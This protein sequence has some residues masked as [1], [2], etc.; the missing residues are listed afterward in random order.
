MKKR[1]QKPNVQTFTTIFSGLANCSNKKVAVAEAVKHY[2]ML[3]QDT[4]LDANIIHTN[5][6]L[7]L[8]SQAHDLDQMLL[9]ANTL[10]NKLRTPDATTYTI[11]FEGIRHKVLAEVKDMEPKESERYRTEM[12]E[13][14]MV[15]WSEVTRKWKAGTLAVDERLIVAMARTYPFQQERNA[16]P[17]DS[18]IL[19]LLQE[20]MGVPNYAKFPDWNKQEAKRREAEPF[21]EEVGRKKTSKAVATSRNRS[22][23]A[24]PG[25]RTLGLILEVLGASRRSSLAIKYWNK[26][27]D[28]FGVQ[29]D[30]DNYFRML[31][32]LKFSKSSSHIAWL[33][34]NSDRNVLNAGHFNVALEAC[35]NDNINT[36]AVNNAQQVLERAK[37]VLPRGNE[38]L[39]KFHR[40]YLRVALVSHHGFRQQSMRGQQRP[41][42]QA[43]G[44][45]ILSALEYLWKPYQDLHRHWFEIAPGSVITDKAAANLSNATSNTQLAAK[46]QNKVF[47][48]APLSQGQVRNSQ[49]E[50]IA[51]ARNIYAAYNKLM[52][53]RMLPEKELA[54]VRAR[55]AS[56]NREIQRF[57]E[58]RGEQEPNLPQRDPSKQDVRRR[59]RLPG[60]ASA[61]DLSAFTDDVFDA[62]EP[63]LVGRG[64][65]EESEDRRLAALAD[66]LAEETAL[67][68]QDLAGLPRVGAEF[69]WASRS[70][71]GAK[72]GTRSAR[73][74]ENQRST[75]KREPRKHSWKGTARRTEAATR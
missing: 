14:A 52:V 16:K 38:E 74:K 49:R 45:Q 39:M 47:K 3:L 21:D 5:A 68:G 35:I 41:A 50:V 67:E 53:E 9:I 28:D 64:P 37:E 56:I 75:T 4:R 23:Q 57:Y 36:N 31:V 6:V 40:M 13:K 20:M 65:E 24:K 73:V 25:T 58:D 48:S 32:L 51:L 63:A 66:Q 33:L 27:V 71:M 19:D 46:N 18:K 55:A 60:A 8:C 29:P 70:P 17:E 7:R 34:K 30:H 69:V 62:E 43:Y 26:L 59:G 72:K 11:L 15:L 2:N 61:K 12:A 1:G 54:P 10:D 42:R 44:R 22:N